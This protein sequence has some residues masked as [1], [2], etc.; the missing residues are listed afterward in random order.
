[1][2]EM[3]FEEEGR[4]QLPDEDP[5]TR[6]AMEVYNP[7]RST[8]KSES[9]Q[10]QPTETLIALEP[11][12]EK[13]APGKKSPEEFC[14]RALAPLTSGGKLTIS[15]YMVSDRLQ[16]LQ[17]EFSDASPENKHRMRNVAAESG[18]EIVEQ[19]N[20]ISLRV[21]EPLITDSTFRHYKAIEIYVPKNGEPTAQS[22]E[23]VHSYRP[24]KDRIAPLSMDIGVI[25][26]SDAIAM[27]QA[28]K[29]T[30]HGRTKPVL[31]AESIEKRVQGYLEDPNIANLAVLAE[32]YR[33]NDKLQLMIS[34]TL[35]QR[36]IRMREDR[37]HDIV[38]ARVE[39]HNGDA[40]M[41]VSTEMHF[42]KEGRP[43]AQNTFV[44]FS[45]NFEPR[46]SRTNLSS[47]IRTVA[48]YVPKQR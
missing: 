12:S 32:I 13:F 14:D 33:E 11:H 23:H 2:L 16:E 19:E 39:A 46:R 43:W 24:V 3:A 36:G 44:Y 47:A 10:A 31:E 20:G 41:I 29:L 15:P 6:L 38:F 9:A 25:E 21:R 48:P 4:S 34:G 18:I 27:S 30:D 28:R 7:I 8:H 22:R 40:G 45:D 1:M 5:G 37:N 26:F 35:H 42:P 17:K